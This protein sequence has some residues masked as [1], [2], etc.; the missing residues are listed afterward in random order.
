MFKKALLALL[1]LTTCWPAAQAS[2][3]KPA[4][5]S[6][7]EQLAEDGVEP[8]SALAKL[9]AANQEFDQM[10]RPEEAA[11]RLPIPPW[12]RVYWHKQH[13]DF[14]VRPGDPTGGYPFVLKEIAEWMVHHQ[15]LRPGDA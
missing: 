2:A 11:D 8:G 9:I 3:Q 6:L 13:P 12:L 5:P 14:E 15:D 4:W 1:L 10:L 7:K